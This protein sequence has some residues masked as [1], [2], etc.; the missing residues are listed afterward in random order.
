MIYSNNNCQN[1]KNLIDEQFVG[2]EMDKPAFLRKQFVVGY[3][4]PDSGV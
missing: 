4:Q 1:D 3:M 2:Y